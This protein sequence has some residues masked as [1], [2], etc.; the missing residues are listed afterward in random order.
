MKNA[1]INLSIS[2]LSSTA[3]IL[4][5]TQEIIAEGSGISQS[6]VSRIFSGHGK[7]ESKAYKEIC[8]YINSKVLKVTPD[9]VIANEKL[10]NAL[11]HIWDGSEQQASIIAG[12]IYSLEGLCLSQRDH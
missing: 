10:I 7:R 9:Q 4:G 2:N 1:N 11:T 3:R 8:K 5:L 6:Q 12:I